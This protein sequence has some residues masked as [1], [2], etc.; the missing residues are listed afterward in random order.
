MVYFVKNGGEN[1]AK[2]FFTPFS[3]ICCGHRFGG[4]G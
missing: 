3:G 2:V 4:P 1:G